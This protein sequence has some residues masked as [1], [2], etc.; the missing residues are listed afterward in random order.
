M[1]VLGHR[2][3]KVRMENYQYDHKRQ[4]RRV[5][6]TG[7]APNV[8]SAPGPT[9]SSAPAPADPLTAAGVEEP[10]ADPGA[11][12]PQRTSNLPVP[13]AVSTNSVTSPSNVCG[14]KPVVN[15]T[16][17]REIAR[18][19]KTTIKFWRPPF[20][21]QEGSV[22]SMVEI[23]QR[24]M[25]V[26]APASATPAPTGAAVYGTTEELFRRLQK[27][28][29]AQTSKSAQASALLTY[30]TIAS[31]FPDGLSLAPGLAVIGPAYDGDLV[32][33]TLRNFCRS[34]R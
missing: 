16:G 31:W 24:A 21:V 5:P 30:W 9:E 19:D 27:A 6:Q 1:A 3:G 20:E 11:E 22:D 26:R 4:R 25:R 12:A 17:I 14:A 32:L 29:A 28:I 23:I 15:M 8:D 7:A 2:K 34:R 13:V 10:S 18:A 33:R